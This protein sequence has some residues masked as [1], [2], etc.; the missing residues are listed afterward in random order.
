RIL[1]AVS[2]GGHESLVIPKAAG[3]APFE[4]DASNIEHQYIRMYCGLEDAE[5]L[6]KDLTQSLSEI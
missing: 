1:M 4:F 2:W 3:I 5:Y 6:I